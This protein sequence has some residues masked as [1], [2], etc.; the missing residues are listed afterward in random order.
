MFNFFFVF[1]FISQFIPITSTLGYGVH[2]FGEI[3]F[4]GYIQTLT[5]CIVQT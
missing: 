3:D 2:C 4:G 5:Y 1:L